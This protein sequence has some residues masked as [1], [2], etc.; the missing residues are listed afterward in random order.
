MTMAAPHTV[1]WGRQ[2]YFGGYGQ[3]EC[4][5]SPASDGNRL[6]RGICESAR[7]PGQVECLERFA[8]RLRDAY[9]LGRTVERMA[10]VE[11][12]IPAAAR[13]VYFSDVPLNTD[14]GIQAFLAAQYAL[15]PR[16]VVQLGEAKGSIWGIGNYSRRVD[17]QAYG[18]S[19]GFRMLRD[20]GNGVVIY[21]KEN[22]E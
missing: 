4:Y 20:C 17:F 2:I 10:S 19:A 21:R 12:T 6:G 1:L 15:A 9:G 5:T 22:T 7:K 16:V 11:G 14:T 8:G 13:T 3:I 18:E